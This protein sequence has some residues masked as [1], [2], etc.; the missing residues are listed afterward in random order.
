ML[1][2]VVQGGTDAGQRIIR[3]PAQDW[4]HVCTHASG[5]TKGRVLAACYLRCPRCGCKRP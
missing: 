4:I 3:K 2:V 5:A 1:G